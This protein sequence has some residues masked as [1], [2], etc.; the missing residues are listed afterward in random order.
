MIFMFSQSK[1]VSSIE[2]AVRDEVLAPYLTNTDK[3]ND[4]FLINRL[5]LFPKPIKSIILHKGFAHKTVFERNDF[6]R[7]STDSLFALLP[8]KLSHL[9]FSSD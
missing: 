2:R 1:V 5:S 3:L 6:I 9:F 4:D 7:K 8:E